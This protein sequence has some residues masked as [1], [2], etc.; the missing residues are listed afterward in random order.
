MHAQDQNTKCVESAQHEGSLPH[1]GF[2]ASASADFKNQFGARSMADH[3]IAG[4]DLSAKRFVVTD[5]NSD[6]GFQTMRAL[7]ANGAEVIGL[8][9]SITSARAACAQ[10]GAA[11]I[12]VA[13][14]ER[15]AAK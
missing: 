12:P 11:Y 15:A 5:R 3:V 4:I 13:S 14:S 7:D 9:S 1:E 10:A 2:T 6:N 8:A